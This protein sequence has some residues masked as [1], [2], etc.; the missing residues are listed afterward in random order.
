[1]ARG[2]GTDATAQLK[3]RIQPPGR[4]FVPGLEKA[5]RMHEFAHRLRAKRPI[6]MTLTFEGGKPLIENLDEVNGCRM[7]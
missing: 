2:N 4:K 6:A 7:F 1:V 3:R 5:E